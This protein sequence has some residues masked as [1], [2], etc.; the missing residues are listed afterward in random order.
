MSESQNKSQNIFQPTVSREKVTD[1]IIASFDI[2]DQL[3]DEF[4]K[5]LDNF[6]FAIHDPKNIIMGIDNYSLIVMQK[7][8][9]KLPENVKQMCDSIKPYSNACISLLQEAL[10][11]SDIKFSIA[12]NQENLNP[13]LFNI[14]NKNREKLKLHQYTSEE[15]MELNNPIT[16]ELS[17]YTENM[18]NLTRNFH[19]KHKGNIDHDV[20]GLKQRLSQFAEKIEKIP[21]II[22]IESIKLT[23]QPVDV[24]QLV[25]NMIQDIKI[26][27]DANTFK[28]HINDPGEPLILQSDPWAL[29]QVLENL[30]YNAIKYSQKNPNSII[31]VLI[32]K[33]GVSVVDQGIGMSQESIK[34]VA[35]FKRGYRDK[36]IKNMFSGTG[37]GLPFA[38][39]INNKL[40]FGDIQVSSPGLTKGST[41]TVNFTEQ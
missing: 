6:D 22:D 21:Y 5:R 41:F 26:N 31:D 13:I 19:H 4:K 35:K 24:F 37:I 1:K 9:S 36:D 29:K 20:L 32:S 30:L 10:N 28:F 7:N 14:I 39:Y 3:P 33:Y 38:N 11:N 34:E 2:F 15:F 12:T 18:I 8:D 40:G 17:L 27:Q 25:Y 16:S 23:K